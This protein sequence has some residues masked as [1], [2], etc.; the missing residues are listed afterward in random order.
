MQPSRQNVG[1]QTSD[2]FS[3]DLIIFSVSVRH[4]QTFLSTLFSQ[5]LYLTKAWCDLLLGVIKSN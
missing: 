3:D 5:A 2:E 1:V 4:S